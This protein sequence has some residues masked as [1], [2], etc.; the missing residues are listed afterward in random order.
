MFGHKRCEVAMGAMLVRVVV[1]LATGAGVLVSA[2]LSPQRP[3]TTQCGGFVVNGRSGYYLAEDRRIT[4]LLV[5]DDES[6][7]GAD[8]ATFGNQQLSFRRPNGC[9]FDLRYRRAG[10]IEIDREE[11]RLADGAVFLVTPFA[12]GR[13]CRQIPVAFTDADVPYPE[14]EPY[15]RMELERVANEVPEVGKFLGRAGP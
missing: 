5:F 6:I 7:A 13:R 15:V 9:S 12:G 14:A 11:Y 8:Q 1:F 10:V 4:F 2:W 3:A